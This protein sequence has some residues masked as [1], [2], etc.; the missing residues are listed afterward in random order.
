MFI[1]TNCNA[2]NAYNS[3]KT[4]NKKDLNITHISKIELENFNRER[5]GKNLLP[6][7]KVKWRSDYEWDSQNKCRLITKPKTK[8][9]KLRYY[10]NRNQ[11]IVSKPV[12]N[13]TPSS[14]RLVY[15][16]QV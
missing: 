11:K 12:A 4:Q 6:S 1:S 5:R 7:R 2:S 15:N 3:L 16:E 8:F 14:S 13:S 9:F 10:F